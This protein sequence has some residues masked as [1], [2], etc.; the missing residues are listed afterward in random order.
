MFFLHKLVKSIAI[1]VLRPVL[2]SYTM[3]ALK[4]QFHRTRPAY[5]I[6]IDEMCIVI[7]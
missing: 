1:A 7:I 4:S 5:L 6:I 3:Y 2:L